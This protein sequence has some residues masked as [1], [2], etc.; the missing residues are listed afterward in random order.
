MSIVYFMV[1]RSNGLGSTFEWSMGS[2]FGVYPQLPSGSPASLGGR[3]FSSDIST[4]HTQLSSRPK[5]PIF[6]SAR[7]RERRPR[8]GGISLHPDSTYPDL[9]GDS[10]G[11]LPIRIL[12]SG[13][14]PWTS[15]TGDAVAGC[16]LCI[17]VDPAGR[18][19]RFF[20]PLPCA[21]IPPRPPPAC[22]LRLLHPG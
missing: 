15:A 21:T 18:V 12:D 10:C 1:L 3:S 14:I 16:A 11:G 6:S 17:P 19:R 7:D 13:E 22:H 2:A 4:I 9:V 5:R 8:S 20:F